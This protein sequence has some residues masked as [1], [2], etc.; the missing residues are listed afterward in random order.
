MRMILLLVAWSLLAACSKESDEPAGRAASAVPEVGEQTVLPTAE[1]LQAEP[2]RS[3]DLERGAR[4]AIQCRTCHSI[5]PGGPAM[6][7]P[8]LGE[9]FGRTA[10]TFAGYP[11]SNVLLSAN[12]VWTP[13]TLDR[14]L[15]QPYRFLPGSQ[16]AFAGMPEKRDR[17]SVIAFLL[18]E[19]DT[20]IDV[21]ENVE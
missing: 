15:E 13:Q 17:D 16:M 7:G 19:T 20:Q 1:Y 2:Y 6:L 3:A 14:C 21:M 10:G 18:H 9:F 8:P 11:Y 4:L 12:F 5:E